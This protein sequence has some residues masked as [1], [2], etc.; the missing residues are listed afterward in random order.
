MSVVVA[1]KYK[2]GVAIAG[3]K[4]TTWGNIKVDGTVKVKQFDLSNTAIGCVGAARDCDI[5]CSQDGLV[6]AADVLKRVR[7]DSK[8]VITRVVPNIFKI[9]KDNHRII[10]ERGIYTMISTMMFATSEDMFII[11]ADGGILSKKD[12]AAIGCGQDLATG[13]L[14]TIPDIHKFTKKQAEKVLEA[15][16][17][18]ACKN[19]VYVNENIDYIFLERE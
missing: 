8:Y 17:K 3:D 11:T 5:I 18:T 13:F 19:D 14:E 6:D 9:L 12:F 4:Q 7:I 1:I 2:D 16:I 15:C 10:D